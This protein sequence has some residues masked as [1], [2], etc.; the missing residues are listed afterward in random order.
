MTLF[1]DFFDVSFATFLYS[2]GKRG[3]VVIYHQ[4]WLSA[5]TS[6]IF[7]K[8]TR[9]ILV[10]CVLFKVDMRIILYYFW[11]VVVNIQS[12]IIY[13]LW[14]HIAKLNPR[15]H[16]KSILALILFLPNVDVRWWNKL[17][18]ALNIHVDS[19]ISVVLKTVITTH[20]LINTLIVTVALTFV[21]FQFLSRTFC[22]Q[23]F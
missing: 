10:A 23:K 21:L 14:R 19:C 6:L 4:A 12:N 7:L 17:W 2:W 5:S 20:C 1:D 16:G 15:N 3:I 18:R 8:C 13:L 22:F 9:H 11:R